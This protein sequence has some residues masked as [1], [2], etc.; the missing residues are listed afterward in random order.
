M[1]EKFRLDLIGIRLDIVFWEYGG[2][3]CQRGYRIMCGLVR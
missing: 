3:V 2:I 1:G